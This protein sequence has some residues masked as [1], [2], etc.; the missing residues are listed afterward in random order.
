MSNIKEYSVR[1]LYW[2]AGWRPKIWGKIIYDTFERLGWH[3]IQN[4]KVLEIGYRDGKM[5]V[6][7]AKHGAYYQGYEIKNGCDEV[8]RRTASQAGVT[9]RTTFKIGDFMVLS[10]KF[11][12]I[13]VKSVLFHITDPAIYKLWLQKINSLLAPGG[14]FI[15]IEN[16]Q[17]LVVNRWARKLIVGHEKGYADNLLYSPIVEKIFIETFAAVDVHYH[18]V[19]SQFTPWPELFGKFESLFIKPNAQNCFIASLICNKN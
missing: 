18:Y 1:D 6:L 9:D 4:K 8:G 7:F 17:G 5:A 19:L 15:A 10:E 13:F 12:Y 16:A 2:F 3:N 14:K 11:D